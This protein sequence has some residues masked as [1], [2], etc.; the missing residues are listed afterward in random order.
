MLAFAHPIQHPIVTPVDLPHRPH[1]SAATTTSRPI[2][3]P[4]SRK[5]QS[6][7]TITAPSSSASHSSHPSSSANHASPLDDHS[8]ARPAPPRT[9]PSQPLQQVFRRED[10]DPHTPPAS[11]SEDNESEH[12]PQPDFAGTDVHTY[13]SDVLLAMLASALT[14]IASLN[15]STLGD[16]YAQTATETHPA[17]S[18]LSDH[19]HPPIWWTLTSA[20]RHALSTTSSLAFHARNVPTITLDQYLQRIHKYCPASNE[21][22]VSLLVYLDR[23]TRLAKDA[24]GK[25]FPIDFYNIHRLIIAGVTVASKFFS[26]VFYTNS[27]YA[28]VGGLPLSELNQL[29]LQ[30]LLLNNFRLTI[31]N[32]EM[33]Y[34]TK[35]VDLQSKIS[36]DVH[37]AP[38]LPH[39]SSGPA[40]LVGPSELFSA[41]HGYFAH[42]QALAHPRS[43]R[44]FNGFNDSPYDPASE[45]RMSKRARS[46]SVSDVTSEAETDIESSTD[47]EPTIRA[48]HSSA[49]S[50]TMSLH[51]ADD[52]SLFTDDG[53]SRE[54]DPLRFVFDSRQ[55]RR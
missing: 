42:Q 54:E 13:D 30:F 32:E 28:K 52:D 44:S 12:Q 49:S 20:S 51:S 29:E 3:P 48:P 50:E 26:D 8:A 53:D 18:P 25:T 24:C 43:H 14:R 31:S 55:A 6:A 34:F 40:S 33:Q 38:Y 1:S 22:F 2:R 10:D 39:A 45:Y 15:N 37:L 36:M 27:R 7:F 19:P 35:M 17:D 23:M 47:D 21:V 16:S 11:D 5:L 41:V 46:T 4:P 9:P